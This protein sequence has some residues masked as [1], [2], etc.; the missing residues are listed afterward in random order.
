MMRRLLCVL[1]AAALGLALLPAAPVVAH[2]KPTPIEVQFVLR[3]VGY[4]LSVDNVYG[5][6]TMKAV[7]H[8]QRANGLYA[9]GIVGARTWAAMTA[10][11]T[12]TAVRIDPPVAQGLNGLPFAP[13]GLDLCQEMTWY[14]IQAG[15]PDRFDG[16]GYRE[17]RCRNDVR[18]WCCFGHFQNFLS[19]HLS[20]QSQYRPGIINVCKVTQVSD[21]YGTHPLQKQK[22]ACVTRIVYDISGFSPWAL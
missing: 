16:I 12:A 20:S 15:L 8:W 3:S 19:S 13:D 4:V 17:S 7:R 9:D 10:T 1:L 11:A 21:F 18:T 6:Q 22:Q 14:R 2:D 5:P